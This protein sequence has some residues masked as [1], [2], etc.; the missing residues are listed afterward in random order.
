MHYPHSLST[1][2][3]DA[4]PTISTIELT[5]L[6]CSKLLY[7]LGT[8]SATLHNYIYC[9]SQRAYYVQYQS[10]PRYCIIY[11]PPK[12]QLSPCHSQETTKQLQ[13]ILQAHIKNGVPKPNP[14][15]SKFK[16]HY[17]SGE[18]VH[19]LGLISLSTLLKDEYFT[20]CMEEMT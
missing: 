6:T 17:L 16:C 19:L 12:Q 13:S 10:I 7:V 3:T 9:H 18:C 1:K 5:Q 2:G 4:T 15:W 20:T 11:N 14:S 8:E